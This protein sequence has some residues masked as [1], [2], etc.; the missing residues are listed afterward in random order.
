MLTFFHSLSPSLSSYLSS[1]FDNRSF[2]FFADCPARA[3]QTIPSCARQQNPPLASVST[4]E[5]PHR[6]RWSPTNM[7]TDAVEHN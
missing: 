7:Q 6:F 5:F 3:E 1:S 2:A 4:T